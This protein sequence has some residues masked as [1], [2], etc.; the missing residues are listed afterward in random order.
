LKIIKRLR[1]AKSFYTKILPL[2]TNNNNTTNNN[3]N[4][5]LEPEKGWKEKGEVIHPSPTACI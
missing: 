3:S 2:G 5:N 1:A 4:A